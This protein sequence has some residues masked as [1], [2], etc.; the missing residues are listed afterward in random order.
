[1]LAGSPLIPQSPEGLPPSLLILQWVG[2]PERGMPTPPPAALRGSCPSHSY[3]SSP[4]CLPL[5][6]RIR[7]ALSSLGGLRFR[8]WTPAGLRTPAGL[9][10]L[11]GQRR[12][13]WPH[14]LLVPVPWD[15]P[16]CWSPHH[17]WTPAS[18][19]T[20]PLPQPSLRV[21]G[22]PTRTSPPLLAPWVLPAHEGGS[23]RP[24]RCPGSRSAPGS[25]PSCEETNSASSYLPS[26]LCLS[27]YAFL[28]KAV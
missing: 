14:S 17:E 25:G 10:G 11:S 20:S 24:L 7:E 12:Q 3:F 27:A 22:P 13:H 18:M 15:P 19:G 28:L 26:W 4:F 8:V 16:L 1:M 23:S 9:P 2:T 21:A 6:P 5:A